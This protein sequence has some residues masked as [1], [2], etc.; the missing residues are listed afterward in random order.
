VGW[1]AIWSSHSRRRISPTHWA[2]SFRS[3]TFIPA[4]S[5]CRWMSWTARM[6]SSWKTISS[7]Y[8]SPCSRASTSGL[9]PT[10]RKRLP[11]RS[12]IRTQKSSPQPREGTACVGNG[13]SDAGFS[14]RSTGFVIS[15]LHEGQLHFS[16]ASSWTENLCESIRSSTY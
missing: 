6:W 7:P 12:V 2:S 15:P 3:A 9:S 5:S 8:F 14:C 16:G 11:D 13:T 4:I 1:T 10:P